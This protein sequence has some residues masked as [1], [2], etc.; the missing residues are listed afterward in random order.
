MFGQVGFAL[1]RAHENPPYARSANGL[2][3]SSARIVLT[4]TMHDRFPQRSSAV[5]I[6]LLASLTTVNGALT[7]IWSTMRGSHPEAATVVGF[8]LTTLWAVYATSAI[9]WLRT[10]RYRGAPITPSRPERR[11]R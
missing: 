10:L 8:L 1:F 3:R 6:V 4:G 9:G 2:N 11:S 5:Q 7:L